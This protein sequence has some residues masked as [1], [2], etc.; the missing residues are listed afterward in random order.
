MINYKIEIDGYKEHVSI[1][2]HPHPN[3]LPTFKSHEDFR[4]GAGSF[5]VNRSRDMYARFFMME[6]ADP[7]S[8]RIFV[9]GWDINATA[10]APKQVSEKPPP[11]VWG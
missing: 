3:G 8:V 5:S 1:F 4:Y 2:V 7:R 6:K 9:T 11:A 10:S